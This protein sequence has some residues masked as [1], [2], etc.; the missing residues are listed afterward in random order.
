MHNLSLYFRLGH[1]FFLAVFCLTT[2]P[3]ALVRTFGQINLAELPFMFI[4]LLGLIKFYLASAQDSAAVNA[5]VK[6]KLPANA[7]KQEVVNR[8]GQYKNAQDA[9]LLANLVLILVLNIYL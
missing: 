7:S 8:A 6:K 9:A 3:F 5:I 2:A 4:A 1:K